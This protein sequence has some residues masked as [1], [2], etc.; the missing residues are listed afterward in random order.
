MAFDALEK[1]AE[2][3]NQVDLLTPEQQDVVSQLTEEEVTI[4]T[5][6][7]AKMNAVAGEDVEG[8]DVNIFRIG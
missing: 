6:V 8:Q 7:Q 4:L 1:L 2:A 5:S 3:G